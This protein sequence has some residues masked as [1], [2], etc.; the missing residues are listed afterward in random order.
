MRVEDRD[1]AYLWDMLESAQLIRRF[2]GEKNLD[3]YLRDKMLQ[4]AVERKV[5]IIGEAARKI[6]DAFKKS[7]PEIPWKSIIA[8]RNVMVHDY[9]EIKQDRV[10]VVATK[11]VPRLISQINPLLPPLPP[12]LDL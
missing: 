3:E 11:H 4:S 2:I 9:G 6:S 1:A 5:E 8:Q 7:H 10:W 12:E